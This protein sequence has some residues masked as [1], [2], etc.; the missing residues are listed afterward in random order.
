MAKNKKLKPEYS[1]ID[2]L[3]A[4]FAAWFVW[5]VIDNVHTFVTSGAQN[6]PAT[7]AL[8]A[9][10]L[11][12]TYSWYQNHKLSILNNETLAVIV[13]ALSIWGFGLHGWLR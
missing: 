5:S 10:L 8:T 7:I 12:I 11:L 6:S 4:A 13:T 9:S 1:L 2:G 3:A